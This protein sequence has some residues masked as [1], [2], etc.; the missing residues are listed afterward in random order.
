MAM[1]TLGRQLIKSFS[2]PVLRTPCSKRRNW[3]FGSWA[4]MGSRRSRKVAI[5]VRTI[6][7]RPVRLDV[8]GVSAISRSRS[9][10]SKAWRPGKGAQIMK[11][12]NRSAAAVRLRPV[13]TSQLPPRAASVPASGSFAKSCTLETRLRCGGTIS[14]PETSPK[15]PTC[16]TRTHLTPVLDEHDEQVWYNYL[17]IPLK[18][19]VQR[20]RGLNM[21][22]QWAT[23]PCVELQAAFRPHR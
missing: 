16:I 7:K 18:A 19:G 13:W 15:H 11:M 12:S 3:E 6:S 17:Q 9:S 4:I 2:T 21:P 20:L 8:Q 10:E 22:N 14:R 23:M 5:L 1:K